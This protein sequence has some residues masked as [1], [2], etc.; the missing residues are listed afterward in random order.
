MLQE[1][2]SLLSVEFTDRRR[3]KIEFIWMAPATNQAVNASS[4]LCSARLTQFAPI[5]KPPN[6][7]RAG[8]TTRPPP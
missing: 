5:R 6:D 7:P 2:E 8:G 1:P 3:C 4:G